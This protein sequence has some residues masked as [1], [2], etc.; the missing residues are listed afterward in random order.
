MSS[1][2]WMA[3]HACGIGL[4]RCEKR[5]GEVEYML[6]IFQDGRT[7]L[8]SKPVQITLEDLKYLRQDIHVRGN[9]NFGITIRGRARGLII[10][11]RYFIQPAERERKT[12]EELCRDI[13]QL[14]REGNYEVCIVKGSVRVGYDYAKNVVYIDSVEIDAERL[15]TDREVTYSTSYP[16]AYIEMTCIEKPCILV[17]K[18]KTIYIP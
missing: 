2:A 16:E 11:D 4:T 8:E 14:Y 6:K 3:V 17:K 18:D 9:T 7:M 15:V 5:I 1:S 12:F 10:N 13:G